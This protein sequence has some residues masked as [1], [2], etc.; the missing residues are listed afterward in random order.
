MPTVVTFMSMPLAQLANGNGP[1]A[2][3]LSSRRISRRKL[4][5][6]NNYSR[7]M[8][9]SR[10][11]DHV[12]SQGLSESSLEMMLGSG[13]MAGVIIQAANQP[14][15]SKHIIASH[16]GICADDMTQLLDHPQILAAAAG[17]QM[18][19]LAI[20]AEDRPLSSACMSFHVSTNIAFMNS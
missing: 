11:D 12:S 19:G 1:L 7:R 13:T 2:S 16:V 18:A 6:G 14:L 8:K 3:A 4:S 5:P 17:E 20:C 9:P 10:M 15:F